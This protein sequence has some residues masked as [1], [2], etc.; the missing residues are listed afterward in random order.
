[1]ANQ[2]QK[3]DEQLTIEFTEIKQEQ[4]IFLITTSTRTF[5]KMMFSLNVFLAILISHIQSNQTD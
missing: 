3:V 4:K 5:Y 2:V 1:M